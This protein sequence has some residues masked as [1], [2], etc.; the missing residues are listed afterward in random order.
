MGVVGEFAD[1]RLRAIRHDRN[2]GCVAAKNTGLAE[3]KGTFVAVLDADDLSD[4]VRL[5]RQLGVLRERP[6]VVL[7][8]TWCHFIDADGRV[9]HTDRPPTEHDALYQRLSH[10][11]PL[12]HS[13]IMVQ[14]AAALEV[15]GYPPDLLY[16]HDYGL[17][18]RLLRAGRA[19][20]VPEALVQYRMHGGSMTDSGAYSYEKIFDVL[21]VT[22]KARGLPGLTGEARRL[23]VRGI[24]EA[25]M[26]GR[27]LL[28]RSRRARD[29]LG[30]AP[31]IGARLARPVAAGPAGTGRHPRCALRHRPA[32]DALTGEGMRVPA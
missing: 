6:D 15:G 5:E 4:P 26:A 2:R 11:N 27:A 29:G 30:I 14:R 1:P 7:L 28:C 17:Y 23:N 24:V 12:T 8:G 10:S 19:A 16:A 9:F 32:A 21:R 25:R 3:A 31:G 13:T 20:L 18:I 22:E